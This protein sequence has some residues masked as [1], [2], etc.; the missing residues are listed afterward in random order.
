[1]NAVLDAREARSEL[2]HKLVNAYH[3]SVVVAKLNVVGPVKQQSQ[4]YWVLRQAMHH[5]EKTYKALI[6]DKHIKD[7]ADGPYVLYVIQAE[8]TLLKKAMIQFE[9]S[10]PA[11]RLLDLDVT[12]E[13]SVS[14]TQLGYP[15]RKCI[16]CEED[17]DRCARSQAHDL[18]SVLAT[19]NDI[20]NQALILLIKNDT[21]Q[22][23]KDELSLYPC[24]GLVSYKDSGAHTDMDYTTFEQSINALEETI[25]AYLD[26]PVNPAR[27]KAIGQ[28]GEQAMFRATN[29]INTHKGLIFLLGIF[30]PTLKQA[31]QSNQSVED[32]K[33]MIKQLSKDIVG[34]Y[35][36]HLKDPKTNGD[37]V[38]MNYHIK[39]VRQLAC[40]GLEEVFVDIDNRY[41]LL[42]HLMSQVD[43][44]TIV[45]RFDVRTLR[46]VQKDMREFLQLGGA[47]A[48]WSIYQSL[49]DAYKKQGI[50][51]GG[52]ADL[53]VLARVFQTVNYL[54]K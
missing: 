21:I 51:P 5:I 3:E 2:I 1:M 27:L 32:L 48:H 6:L 13:A 26:V 42:C 31:I 11:G 36:D 22:A 50:S 49:S 29:H 53:W 16:I 34:N 7:S 18:E 41:D 15:K 33:E 4:F 24:F 23:M 17:A 20:A 19:M 39:G 25:E 46:A 54:I 43:D 37:Y 12:R 28:A 52:S 35:Y 44:T 38:Y 30:L 10:L 45:H 14:R 47:T 40:N 8:P 9:A